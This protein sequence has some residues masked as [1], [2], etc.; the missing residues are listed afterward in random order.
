MTSKDESCAGGRNLRA[1]AYR[2]IG[3]D[4]PIIEEQKRVSRKT[5][6]QKAVQ[7][8]QQKFEREMTVAQVTK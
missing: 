8:E 2:P 4:D 3:I 1:T 5:W 6:I 7:Q